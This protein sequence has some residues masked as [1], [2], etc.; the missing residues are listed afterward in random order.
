MD[1]NIWI[2]NVLPT[3][4]LPKNKKSIQTESKWMER[5]TFQANGHKKK[6][7][8][9]LESILVLDKID[10]KKKAIKK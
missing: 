2:T 4:D 5:N 1:K 9:K 8:T 3:R 10:F 6:T 7:K